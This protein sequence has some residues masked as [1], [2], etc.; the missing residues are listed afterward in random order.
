LQAL[1]K[2]SMYD[3]AHSISL[4]DFF[5]S[6]VRDVTRV[7]SQVARG[8][9]L[10]LLITCYRRTADGQEEPEPKESSVAHR[11]SMVA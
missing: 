5:R 4:Q 1:D 11:T 8:R 2:P 9:D 10:G 3:D 7:R 6:R